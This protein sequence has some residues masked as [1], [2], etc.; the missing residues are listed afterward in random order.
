M[1][2]DGADEY[3]Q[4][5]RVRDEVGQDDVVER[6]PQRQRLAGGVGELELWMSVACRLEHARADV[7]ADASGRREGGKQVA[8]ATADLE[9]PRVRRDERGVDRAHQRVVR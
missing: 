9:N 4:V 1:R 7:D 3:L 5:V 8:A 6:F 2:R